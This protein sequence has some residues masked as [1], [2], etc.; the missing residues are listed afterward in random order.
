MRTFSLVIVLGFLLMLTGCCAMK[1]G[2]GCGKCCLTKQ[3]DVAADALY[4]CNCGPSCKCNSVSKSPGKCSCGSPLK[5]GHVLKVEGDEALVCMC[6]EGCTCKI[7][8]KDS[9]KCGCGEP[10]K[11]V[12]LK[13]TGLYFCNC[14]GSCAC[15]T[16]MAGPGTCKCGMQLKKVD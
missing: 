2:P 11:R 13:G 6:K 10:T 3:G 12:P 8:P 16:V 14:G 5:M 15:N 1:G 4:V 7:D 9:T